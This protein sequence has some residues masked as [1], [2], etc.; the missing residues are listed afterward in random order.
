[1][2]ACAEGK[3]EERRR[4]GGTLARTVGIRPNLSLSSLLTS[5]EF[6]VSFSA[7]WVVI[8]S[9]LGRTQSKRRG[10][11]IFDLGCRPFDIVL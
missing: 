10:T 3:R 4:C 8:F 2:T 5:K 1:M 7:G 9:M 6:S 11:Y